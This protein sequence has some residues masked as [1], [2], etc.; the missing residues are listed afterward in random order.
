MATGIR[1]LVRAR[2]RADDLLDDLGLV[3]EG[4]E[5]R[6][7]G[8]R[9][10]VVARVDEIRAIE[11]A[12]RVRLVVVDAGAVH[13]RSCAGRRTSRIG[14]Y[15]PL[16]PVGAELPGGFVI[17][18]RKMRRCARQTACCARRANYDLSDDHEGLMILDDLRRRAS[19]EGLLQALGIVPDVVFEI[20]VEGNRPDAW[21][22]EG[23]A[24]RLGDATPTPS[25][26]TSLRHPNRTETSATVASPRS[27]RLNSADG[28]RSWCF[29][30][31][32]LVLRH[33][34]SPN[35]YWARVCGPYRTSSTPRTS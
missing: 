12:D 14:N 27:K 22:V 3:V 34:G 21:C 24:P 32:G 16:A 18:E 30:M 10:V 1:R 31:L 9:D 17:T 2:R 13:S 5:T 23:V 7:R 15:V 35:D 33:R 25:G 29:V 20:L 4:V 26:V 28:S 19:G 8:P 11:G 6:G